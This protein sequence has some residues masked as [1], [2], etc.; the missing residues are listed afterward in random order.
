M[1]LTAFTRAKNSCVAEF[2]NDTYFSAHDQIRNPLSTSTARNKYGGQT[3]SD[4]CIVRFQEVAG[5]IL[6]ESRP[7][8]V[9]WPAYLAIYIYGH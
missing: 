7:V 2:Q 1:L 6:P 9:K 8:L 3:D 5:L 4:R